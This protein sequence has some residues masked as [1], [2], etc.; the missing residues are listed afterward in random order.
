MKDDRQL[1]SQLFISVQIRGCDLLEIF[2]HENQSYPPAL[3]KNGMLRTCAK[4]DLVNILQSLVTVPDVKPQ[5]ELF[6]VDGACLI[7][8][9]IPHKSKTFE[10]YVTK[11][12]IPQLQRY[13]ST[14][15]RTD[16]IFDVY[17]DSSLKA[18]ARSNRGKALRRRVTAKS[19]TP[20]NWKSFLRDS[21]NKTELF[22]FIADI[23]STTNTKHP[24]IVTRAENIV[25]S[26]NFAC[27]DVEELD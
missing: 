7:N 22:Q 6:I 8:A 21:A 27:L 14:Y 10:E 26:A 20:T 23:V 18:E 5:S 24:L 19:K 16:I 17:R 2:T 12:I 9:K 3:S 4:S 13:S 11:D 25:T 15:Q 1:F